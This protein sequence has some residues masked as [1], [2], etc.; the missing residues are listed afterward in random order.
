MEG[1]SVCGSHCYVEK[2]RNKRRKLRNRLIPPACLLNWLYLFPAPLLIFLLQT[3]TFL[4]L[5]HGTARKKKNHHPSSSPL[6]FSHAGRVS[7]VCDGVKLRSTPRSAPW[8]HCDVSKHRNLSLLRQ[9]AVR[10]PTSDQNHW[11]TPG[12]HLV[13]LR[14]NTHK[15]SLILICVFFFRLH[16]HLNFSFN[17]LFVD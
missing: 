9:E 2:K 13:S 10:Q 16:A 7:H 8:F 12:S 6:R 1:V 11:L 4:R 15:T 17:C 3:P 5:S 14:F